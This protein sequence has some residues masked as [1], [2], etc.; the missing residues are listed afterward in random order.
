MKSFLLKNLGFRVFIADRCLFIK[1]NDE[2]FVLL[3]VYVD[4]IVITGTSVDLVSNVITSINVQF[5][6]KDRGSL[7]YFL[8]MEVMSG[9]D[10]LLVNQMKYVQELIEKVGL[11]E[12]SYF[13]TPMTGT[14]LT[15]RCMDTC[16][17]LFH[18][19]TLYIST[20]GVL[21][22]ICVSR[23]YIHFSVNKLS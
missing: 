20:I 11:T 21:Q 18:D 6:L 5:K 17:E 16:F 10:F 2:C 7:N 3:L 19:E 4:Y 8:R 23:P 12:Q 1:F 13:L 22:H 15:C 9:D 14:C